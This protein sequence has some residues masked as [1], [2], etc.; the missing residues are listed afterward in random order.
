MNVSMLRWLLFGGFICW[1]F[2]YVF[3]SKASLASGIFKMGFEFDMPVKI[4]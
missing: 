3:F 1:S 2:E 4:F